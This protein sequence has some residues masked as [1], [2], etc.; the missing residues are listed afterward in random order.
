MP[1]GKGKGPGRPRKPGRPKG[2]KN[3]S[4]RIKVVSEN[5]SGRNVRFKVGKTTMSR[6]RLVKSI[7]NGNHARFHIRIINGVKTP[8]SNPDKS[9]NNNL[10]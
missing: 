4:N 10:D 6:A 2:S 3:K 5:K 9:K 8:V 1:K 7:D